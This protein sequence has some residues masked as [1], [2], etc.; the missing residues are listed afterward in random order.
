M[1]LCEHKQQELLIVGVVVLVVVLFLFVF[2]ELFAWF[3]KTHTI[4]ARLEQ[5]VEGLDNNGLLKKS[6]FNSV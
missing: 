3:T 1:E 4:L 2:R 5:I 6:D